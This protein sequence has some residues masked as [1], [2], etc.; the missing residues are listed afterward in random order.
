M[1]RR[2]GKFAI[3]VFGVLGVAAAHAPVIAAEL[4]RFDISQHG[5]IGDGAT[6]NTKAIQSAIDQCAAAGGGTVVVPK[7][8]FLSGSLFLKPGVNFEL[9]EGA[10]LKGSTNIDDYELRP[11]TRFEGHFAEWRAGL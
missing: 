4:P 5:A 11:S 8:E 3:A 2:L 10:V 9:I 7:G 1:T 6:L